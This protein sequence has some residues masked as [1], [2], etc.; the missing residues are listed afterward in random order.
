MINLCISSYRKA[1]GATF[2]QAEVA[3]DFL[4]QIFC[5][6]KFCETNVLLDG[7]LS[8]GLLYLYMKQ[9]N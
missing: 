3:I 4:F 7:D 9:A 2:I 6:N 8:T 1:T 5:Y